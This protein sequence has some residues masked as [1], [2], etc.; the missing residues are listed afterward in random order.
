VIFPC[1]HGIFFCY[2]ELNNATLHLDLHKKRQWE[3]T[4]KVSKR[5]CEFVTFGRLPKKLF[6]D[7]FKT[8]R[9]GEMFQ[10]EGGIIPLN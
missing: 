2:I 4:Y 1:R 7:R 9:F 8:V 10:I 6:P 5:L 3:N